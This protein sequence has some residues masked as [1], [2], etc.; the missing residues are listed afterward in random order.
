MSKDGSKQVAYLAATRLSTCR[1]TA[2]EMNE[3]VNRSLFLSTMDLFGAISI[4]LHQRASKFTII[5]ISSI[6][7]AQTL[8]HRDASNVGFDSQG[9]H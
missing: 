3:D 7:L 1:A 4:T 9:M 2:I 6:P 8:E 5:E